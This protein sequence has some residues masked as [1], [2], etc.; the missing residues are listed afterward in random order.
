M[1]NQ[2][3]ALRK[4]NLLHIAVA[5]VFILIGFALMM[6]SA[7]TETAFNPDIFSFRRII[8]GPGI[9]FAGFVYIVYAI[10]KK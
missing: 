1:E 3:F 9:S 8:L 7:S 10:L 6:G 4:Q 5:F 2:N